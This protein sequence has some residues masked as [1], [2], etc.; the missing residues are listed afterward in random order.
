MKGVSYYIWY[1]YKDNSKA[2]H[3]IQGIVEKVKPCPFS[4]VKAA[5]FQSCRPMTV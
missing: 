3:H 4:Y 1:M 5:I 2:S